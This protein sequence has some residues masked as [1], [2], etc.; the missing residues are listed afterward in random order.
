MKTDDPGKLVILTRNTDLTGKELFEILRVQYKMELEM[1]ELSYVIA[2]TS[3][4]DTK[5]A[6]NRLCSALTE[7]DDSLDFTQENNISICFKNEM[8]MTPYEAKIRE[9]KLCALEDACGQVSAEYVFLYPPG[10]PVIVPGEKI[11]GETV[12]KIE[13][14]QKQKMNLTGLF[15]DQVYTVDERV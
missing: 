14:Y 9:R 7:I 5:D 2:M 11:S 12:R 10:I 8:V 15:E 4:C 3:I 1:S 6:L 13:Q